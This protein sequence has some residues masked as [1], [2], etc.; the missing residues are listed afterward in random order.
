M[1]KIFKKLLVE[2]ENQDRFDKTNLIV[3]AYVLDTSQVPSE[4]SQVAALAMADELGI[5]E[6]Q[7]DLLYVAFKLVHVGA[8]ANHD[9]FPEDEL[10]AAE[11]TP[12]LKLVNWGHHEPHIGV[13]YASKY[14]EATGDEPGHI[15]VAAA[16][17]KFKYPSYAKEIL[18]RYAKGNLFFSMEVWFKEAEC[19][20]CKSIFKPGE[21]YCN[22]LLT[23]FEPGTAVNRILHKLV[24]A[25]AGV[26]EAPA[27]KMA[28]P[29][30]V[31][32]KKQK[33]GG[34]DMSDNVKMYS[35]EEYK[36]LQEQL[37]GVT[38]EK[39]DLKTELESVRASL[40]DKEKEIEKLNERIGELEKE[41]ADVCKEYED[42]KNAVEAEKVVAQRLNEL[43][44]LGFEVPTD[45]E[46]L[47]ELK[48]RVRNMDDETFAFMKK[49]LSTRFDD[50]DDEPE[51]NNDADASDNTDD[52]DDADLPTGGLSTASEDT[53][54]V[55]CDGLK[56]IFEY[57]DYRRRRWA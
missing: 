54:S 37:D 15:V 3:P 19:S 32:S 35:E 22:H 28:V 31:A 49:M 57:D 46:G 14:V 53:V 47:N 29:I 42:Y 26:V 5:K 1:G 9:F 51:A 11:K 52:K 27:D 8:N 12:I 38:A 24:F 23:R 21:P 25:G 55:V 16:I 6:K 40:A 43:Q 13:I 2:Y 4:E 41:L 17:S 48:E 44:E 33:K 30:S 39:D 56:K 18:E 10:K 36:A 7:E 34:S 20:A 50:G 45:E